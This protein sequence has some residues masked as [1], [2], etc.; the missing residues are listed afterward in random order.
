MTKKFSSMMRLPRAITALNTG[1]LTAVRR[2]RALRSFQGLVPHWV[3]RVAGPVVDDAARCASRQFA[4]RACHQG[5]TI[6]TIIANRAGGPP[7]QADSRVSTR[8]FSGHTYG[9]M[10]ACK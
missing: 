8:F 2:D 6:L 10:P 7:V 9:V 4:A 5:F 1:G 3:G